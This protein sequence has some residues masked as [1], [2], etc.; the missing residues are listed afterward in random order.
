LARERLAIRPLDC[1]GH[2]GIFFAGWQV[3][4]IGST[5]GETVRNVSEQVRVVSPD[6]TFADDGHVDF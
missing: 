5:A 1:D 6:W 4:S 3:A 2:Y